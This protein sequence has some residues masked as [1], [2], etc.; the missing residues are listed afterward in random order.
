[1]NWVATRNLLLTL[2]LF[3]ER[4]IRCEDID[5]SYRAFQAGFKFVFVP[6]AIVYH[7]NEQTYS[8]LFHEGYLHGFYSVQAIKEHRVL[9]KTLGHRRI[10]RNSYRDLLRNFGG[11]LRGTQEARCDFVFNAGK[12]LGKL[13]GSVRFGYVDL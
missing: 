9:L 5:L 2:N 1:M 4:F 11:S 10:H 13:L 6:Q 8:G 7:R 3:D 12:K